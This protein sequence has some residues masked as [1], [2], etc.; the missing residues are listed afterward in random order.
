MYHKFT[1]C[2]RPTLPKQV[3]AAGWRGLGLWNRMRDPVAA[4]KY[5]K[6]SKAA[7]ITYSFIAFNFFPRFISLHLIYFFHFISVH[8]MPWD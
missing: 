5:A 6:W 7:N 1:K 3:Q 2:P 4:V 8:S